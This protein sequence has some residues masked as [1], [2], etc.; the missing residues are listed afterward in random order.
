MLV[1]IT[2]EMKRIVIPRSV[3]VMLVGNARPTRAPIIEHVD[4]IN[5]SGK[6][7]RRFARPLLSKPGPAAKAPVRAT[8][9][10]APLT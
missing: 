2:K 1:I 8:N 4:A 5:A 9:N 7:R 3:C 10:P 6:A